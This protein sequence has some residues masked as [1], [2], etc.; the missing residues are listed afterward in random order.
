M[1]RASFPIPPPRREPPAAIEIDEAADAPCVID[2]NGHA[3]LQ[4]GARHLGRG[5]WRSSSRT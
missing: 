2:G 4:T 1:R 5:A 3:L